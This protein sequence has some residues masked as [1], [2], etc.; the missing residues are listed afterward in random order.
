MGLNLTRARLQTNVGN[1]LLQQIRSKMV[2][3]MGKIYTDRKGK[4]KPFSKKQK[5]ARRWTKTTFKIVDPS[6]DSES[7]IEA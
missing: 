1:S 3:T 4:E 5:Q 7:E 6:S 2:G